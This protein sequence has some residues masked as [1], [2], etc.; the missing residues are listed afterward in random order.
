MDSL[1]TVTQYAITP[2]VGILPWPYPLE[3]HAKEVASAFHVPLAWLAN[4]AH[5][6]TRSRD[7]LGPGP[8]VPVYYFRPFAGEV[9]WGATARIT[10]DLLG[11]LGLRGR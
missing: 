3:P 6:E 5:L 9:I 7:P 10:L 11:L 4:P 1:L 8:S 2:I